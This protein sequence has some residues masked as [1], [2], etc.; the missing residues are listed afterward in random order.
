VDQAVKAA[1]KKAFSGM[2][3]A[4]GAE[5][6]RKIRKKFWFEKFLWFI[7]S[8]GYIVVGG[9]DAQQNEVYLFSFSFC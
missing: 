6:V 4:K 1:E 9:R 3:E 7:S 5:A 8:D 2:K